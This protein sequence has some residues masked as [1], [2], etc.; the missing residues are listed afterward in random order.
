MFRRT[1]RLTN[2]T[3]LVSLA[4]CLCASVIAASN[5][6]SIYYLVCLRPDPAR[7]ALP[8]DEGERMQAAHMANIQKMADD[9]VLVAAGPFDD[10]PVTISGI[11]VMKAA[12]LG[13]AKAIAEGD[14]TVVGHRNLVDTFA[15]HGPPE[16]GTEYFRLHKSNPSTPENMQTR[17][18]L[19]LYH[20]VAWAKL[21]A[22]RASLLAA[23]EQF[24]EGLRKT[25]RLAAAGSVDDGGVQELAGIVVFRPG[26]RAEAEAA[27]IDDPAVKAGLLRV[28]PH[29]WWC[30]DHVLPW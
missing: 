10:T 27:L 12:S 1:H 7:T 22:K 4:L 11:F 30:A 28:E 18:F 26:A 21:A 8:K 17:P 23:H 9:G 16:I 2:R 6:E 15:W 3:C 19:M 24:I 13:Q 20:G 29:M 5:S 14:P 25:G